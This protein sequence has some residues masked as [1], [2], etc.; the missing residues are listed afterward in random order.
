MIHI[1]S[2]IQLAKRAKTGDTATLESAPP[3]SLSTLTK[4]SA[5]TF[6]VGLLHGTIQ[7]PPGVNIPA[8]P[9]PILQAMEQTDND[10]QTSL[11]SHVDGVLYFVFLF[12]TVQSQQLQ[13]DPCMAMR[14]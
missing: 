11:T 6:A 7:A 1:Q 8:V 5:R 4:M 9:L 3:A 2:G 12:Y 10:F 14:I 13:L